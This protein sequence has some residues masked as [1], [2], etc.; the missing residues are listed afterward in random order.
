[1]KRD[2]EDYAKLSSAVNDKI[3]VVYIQ[4]NEIFA[5]INSGMYSG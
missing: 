2:V 5:V 1:M 4:A 3:T